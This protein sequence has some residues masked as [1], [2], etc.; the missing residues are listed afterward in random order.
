MIDL[1]REPN[2]MV[3]RPLQFSSNPGPT[4]VTPSPR[5][6]SFN[7]QQFTKTNVDKSVTELGISIRVSSLHSLNAWLPMLVTELGISN[8]LNLL[9]KNA[10][11]PMLVMD[12]GIS[13]SSRGQLLKRP[14]LI[15]E[16]DLGKL[17]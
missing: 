11:P 5:M 1:I 3:F 8:S 15:I 17:A 2:I 4:S 16:S 7:P 14:E 12:E 10:E 6:N 13:I 9:P